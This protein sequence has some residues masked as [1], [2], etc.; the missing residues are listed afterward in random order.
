MGKRPESFNTFCRET[1]NHANE[2]AHAAAILGQK[3]D[4]SAMLVEAVAGDAPPKRIAALA[5][6]SS[7]PEPT[8]DEG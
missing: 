2:L 1:W 8:R 6:L 5:Y 4:W 7:R 3:E